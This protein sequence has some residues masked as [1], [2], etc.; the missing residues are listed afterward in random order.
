VIS[1][2]YVYVLRSLVDKQFYVG[3][4]NDVSERLSMHNAG[5]VSSTKLRVPFELVYWEG[6]L[7]RG[8]AAQRE[9]YLKTAWGKR[10]LKL[11]LRQYLTG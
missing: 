7:N 6:C 11:R 1:K 4:T 8:D 9:K 2:H 10:Y 5:L 3:L